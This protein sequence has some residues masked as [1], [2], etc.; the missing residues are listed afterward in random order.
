MK[1]FILEACADSVESACIATENGANRLELCSNLIIGGTTP[2]LALFEEV[3]KRCNNT[4]HVLIRPRFGDFCYSDY[5]FSVL[6]KEILQFER[7]GADGVVIGILKP[8]GSLDCD[9]LRECMGLAEEMKVT[10]HRAI[11]VCRDPYEALEQAVELGMDYILTSGQEETCL[12][13]AE[14]I[15]KL[16]EKA[17]GR[18][19][20][21][22]GSGMKA[23]VIEEIHKKTGVKQFHMS[24]KKLTE[25]RME[26]RKENVH[27][28]TEFLSEFEIW[29]TDAEAIA[30]ASALLRRL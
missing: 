20:V 3:R 21:M 5:E 13:G 11:D 22:A 19:A 28:G 1:D 24:G 30:K 16:K 17:K 8:N 26:Y 25:S 7:A 15:A 29:Q 2:T 4:I 23:E 18:I 6:K 14:C 27:M 9:R 12:Q 10:L